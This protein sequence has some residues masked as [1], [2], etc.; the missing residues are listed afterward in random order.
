MTKSNRWRGRRVPLVV[1]VLLST[2]VAT[3][4]PAWAPT[5]CAFG[6][7]NQRLAF[8]AVDSGLPGAMVS[9]ELGRKDAAYAE[10]RARSYLI[11][12]WETFNLACLD[13]V[14]QYYAIRSVANGRYVSAEVG[15][16]GNLR[17]RARSPSL[18]PG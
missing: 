12:E 3:A 18:A 1:V 4:A 16:T 17:L 5:S 10:S 9:A 7:R 8:W 15:A 13:G 6:D 11:G 2:L 14:N